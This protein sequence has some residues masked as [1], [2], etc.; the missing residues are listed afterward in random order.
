VAVLVFGV[1]SATALPATTVGENDATSSKAHV[2]DSAA[3]PAVGENRRTDKAL[4]YDSKNEI[5]LK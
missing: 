1:L 4:V 5:V 3:Q 2:S